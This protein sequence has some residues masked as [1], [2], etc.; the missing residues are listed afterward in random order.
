MAF[1]DWTPEDIAPP[2][3][4]LD[5]DDPATLVVSIDSV[6]EW[7]DKTETGASFLGG[8]A[9]NPTVTTVNGRGAVAFANQYLRSASLSVPLQA[10]S[11]FVVA[12][13]DGSATNDGIISINAAPEADFSSDNGFH[14]CPVKS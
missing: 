4:W 8:S 9:A 10:R 14:C 11:I 3:L 1:R 2:F 13:D 6:A 7:N 12:R 5:A